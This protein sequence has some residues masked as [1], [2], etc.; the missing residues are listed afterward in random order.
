MAADSPMLT[1]PVTRGL[2]SHSDIARLICDRVEKLVDE[3]VARGV[4]R[5]WSVVL[6]KDAVGVGRD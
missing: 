6:P 5:Q 1:E 2:L 4:L 3:R